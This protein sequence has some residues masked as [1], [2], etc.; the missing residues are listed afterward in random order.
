MKAYYQEIAPDYARLRRVHPEVFRHL[1]ADGPIHLDSRVLEI[2]CGTGNYICGLQETVRCNCSG[3]DPSENMLAEAKA[4]STTVRFMQA[5]A[6]KLDFPPDAF[7]L[8]F[9]VDV[10][11]HLTGRTQAFREAHRVL[12]RDGRLCTVTDS[13]EI[14]RNRHPQSVYFPETVAVE[15]AR[16]PAIGALEK[17]LTEAGFSQLVRTQVEFTKKLES[18][19]P[20]RARVYSSLRLI[21]QDAFDRGMARLENDFKK[22]P[23]SWV[24]RYLMLWATK[25]A[26]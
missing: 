12:R 26:F 24:S 1:I 7:D 25:A 19:E 22:G 8:I 21:P 10:V 4:R 3:I 5:S 15:L 14:L 6:E 11:H 23:V 17:E 13:E 20:Y 2:G 9:S 16:Y 18:L